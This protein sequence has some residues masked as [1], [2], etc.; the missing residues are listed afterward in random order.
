MHRTTQSRW[1]PVLVLI[2]TCLLPVPAVAHPGSGIVVDRLG[3]IYFVDMVSGVWKLDA[4]GA[5]THMPGPAFHW[6]L[7]FLPS[8]RT[9][10][11]ASLSATTDQ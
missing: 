11:F 8:G 3:Q 5:L 2:V 9:S 1:L 4:R 6:I 10:I 7:E